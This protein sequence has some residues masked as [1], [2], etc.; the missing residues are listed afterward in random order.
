MGGTKKIW[1]N[2]LECPTV[3]VG[4]GRTVA[5]KSSIGG[6]HVCAGRLDILKI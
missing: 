6:F 5:K 2:C 3:S 1:G 4:L